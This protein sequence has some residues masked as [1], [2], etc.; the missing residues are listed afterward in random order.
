MQDDLNKEQQ[1]AEPLQDKTEP[2]KEPAASGAA[3]TDSVSS[4]D[5]KQP[6]PQASPVEQPNVQQNYGYPYGSGNPAGAPPQQP[7]YAQQNGYY[8]ANPNYVYYGAPQKPKKQIEKN[9]KHKKNGLRIFFGAVAACLVLAVIGLS[10]ALVK[11]N[12]V[13][14]T[15]TSGDS[16]SVNIAESP[17]A[18]STGTDGELTA[19]GVYEKV[20]ESSV[21]VLVYSGNGF[22]NTALAGEGSG[23]I[24]GEDTTGKYTYIV[25]C[26]HV[27]SDGGTIK[28]QL[29]DETQYDATVVGYDS[30][31]D[32]GVLRITATGLKAAELGDSDSLSVGETVY[33]IGNPGGVAFAGSFTNGIVSAISRPVDSEIGYEMLCIQ[34]TAAINPGNSG[35]ALVNAY[36]QVIGINSSKIA[37]T[38]YEGMGF[39]VPSVTVKEVFDEIVANGYVTNRPKLGITYFS[40]SSNQMYSMIA[41]VNKLPAGTI[42]IQSISSDSPLADTDVQQGDMIIKA[43]GKDLESADT[44]PDLIENAN[45]GDE[46]TLTIARVDMQNNYTLSQF[47]VKV[48]LVEDKGTTTATAEPTTSSSYYNPFGAYGYGN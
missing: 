36:G 38:D 45:V 29:Y 17:T 35:G 43:N 31:T 27:I 9:S 7:P 11:G 34:H 40:V 16:A 18:S 44:L 22:S 32:I 39:A 33:A 13:Q 42:V 21:G 37:S 5:V 20:K 15:T 14:K 2:V 26:A 30:R 28:V 12:N 1:P 24:V 23:V 6:E 8:N 48:T 47:D 3:E 46:M 4:A 25:T 41:G 19:K 10:V